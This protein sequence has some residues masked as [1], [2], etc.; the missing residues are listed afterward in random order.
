MNIPTD[1]LRTC[2]KTNKHNSHSCCLATVGPPLLLFGQSFCSF[3]QNICYRFLSAPSHPVSKTTPPKTPLFVFFLFFLLRLWDF[4]RWACVCLEAHKLFGHFIVGPLREYPHD[5][6]AR[7]IHRNAPYKRVVGRAAAFVRE[8]LE[9]D[10]RHADDAVFPGKAVVLYRNVELV[11]LWTMFVTQNT[12]SEN[13]KKSDATFWLDNFRCFSRIT[14][15]IMP[16]AKIYSPTDFIALCYISQRKI[17]GCL[18]HR[19]QIAFGAWHSA[20]FAAEYNLSVNEFS[21][22]A[23]PQREVSSMCTAVMR[24]CSRVLW[25]RWMPSLQR[26]IILTQMFLGCFLIVPSNTIAS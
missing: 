20:L 5:C 26:A 23:F 14:Q 3:Q 16:F 12:R 18:Y 15:Q 17:I 11:D 22:I 8:L 10:D 1:V 24:K 4:L 6:E 25:R 9:L 13:I 7:F 19:T 21:L 2:T